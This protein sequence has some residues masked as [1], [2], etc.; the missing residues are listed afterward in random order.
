ML[1]YAVITITLALLLYTTGVLAE[2]KQGE[3]KKWHLVI[4]WL[5]FVFDTVGTT[6]MRTL[7]SGEFRLNFHGVTGML[8]IIIMFFHAVWATVVLVSHQEKMMKNFH[9]FSLVAWFIWLIPFVSG[10]M[11]AMVNR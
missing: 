4:F 1:P 10:M 8:A 9:K 6:L 7:A 5:G 11:F 2:K 3:L